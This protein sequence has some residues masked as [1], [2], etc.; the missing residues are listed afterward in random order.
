MIHY[1][2]DLHRRRRGRSFFV[3]ENCKK[4]LRSGGEKLFV[5]P[6]Q[7]GIENQVFGRFIL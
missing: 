5:S 4:G 3:L 7:A 1:S 6:P 2:Y